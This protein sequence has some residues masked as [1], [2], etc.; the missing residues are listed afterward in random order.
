MKKL[1]LTFLII[2]FTLISNVVLSAD[3]VKGWE[4]YNRGDYAT[5]LLEWR[6]LAEEGNEIAQFNLGNS[7][8]YGNGVPQNY[9]SAVKWYKLA[10]NQG[11]ADAQFNLGNS[12]YNGNGVP[13]NYK[14]A[15]KWYKLAANQGSNKAQWNLGIMYSDGMGVEKN[16]I[17]GYMYAVV[18]GSNADGEWAKSNMTQDELSTAKKLVKDCKSANNRC[19]TVVNNLVKEEVKNKEINYARENSKNNPGFR[20]LKP[21][22]PFED[23]KKI[24]PGLVVCYGLQDIKFDASPNY[25]KIKM[26]N[27]LTLDMG[28]IT[29]DGVFLDLINEFAD[30]NANIFRKMKNNFDTK[31]LLDYEFSNRD[32]Q[33][34]NKNEKSILLVVYSKG[35]VSLRI[36]RKKRK[37][38]YA[39]DLWLYI[40]YRDVDEAKRYLKLNRP[41]T[42]TLNDF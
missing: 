4:A 3:F 39:K 24:C 6:P 1:L 27:V 17:L 40:E 28:P 38:S 21:G 12:Y 26:V 30:P 9:K 13:Q 29:S 31:Y 20:D 32:R 5:A 22:M 41:V 16:Y 36:E 10:A 34:F 23:Y 19:E 18:S 35:Q 14:S 33:L 2:L 37:D 11:V 7:Y 42:S 15:V 25:G 8:Y